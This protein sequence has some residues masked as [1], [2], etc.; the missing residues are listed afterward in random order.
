M[1]SQLAYY[2][3]GWDWNLIL[4]A[5]SK[6]FNAYRRVVQQAFQPAVVTQSY[7]SVMEDEIVSFLGRLLASPQDLIK[8]IKQCVVF[9][10]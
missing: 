5:Y 1:R 8:H 10:S 7:R 6:T 2:R 9:E 3:L 4:M